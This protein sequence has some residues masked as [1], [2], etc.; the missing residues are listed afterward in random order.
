MP[1]GFIANIRCSDAC[2]WEQVTEVCVKV[3]DSVCTNVTGEG[4]CEACVE[5]GYGKASATATGEFG[6]GGRVRGVSG[7]SATPGVFRGGRV[8]RKH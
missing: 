5:A 1:E 2:G 8:C 3:S 6:E 4:G 7:A